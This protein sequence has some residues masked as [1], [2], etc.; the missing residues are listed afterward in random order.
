MSPGFPVNAFITHLDIE[1]G[2]SSLTIEAYLGDID[3]YVA[4]LAERGTTEP[5]AVVTK[6]IEDYLSF[7]RAEGRASKTVARAFAAV[8]AFHRFMH[9]EGLTQANPTDTLGVSPG[10]RKLPDVLSIEEIGKLIEAPDIETPLGLRDRAMLEFAYATG[11]RVS[12]LVNITMQNVMLSEALVRIMGK[13]AKERMVPMG[14][15]ARKYVDSY[16]REVRPELAKRKSRDV[17]FLSYRGNPMTRDGYWKLLKKYVIQAGITTHT[18][19]HTLRH[20][21]ATHLLAGGADI[22]VIQEL[23]GHATIATTE[24]YTHVDRS[25]LKEVHGTYHPRA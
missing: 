15:V 11:S 8:R 25:Y 7:L 20:S 17:L 22:R 21:F 6:D 10:R 16:L 18:S 9:G 12:E 13:G 4:W 1:A 19:P 24:V 2:S 3:R 23:L 14:S 5:G